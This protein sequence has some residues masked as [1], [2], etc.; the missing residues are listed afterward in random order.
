MASNRPPPASR[1]SVTVADAPAAIAPRLAE[2]TPAWSISAGP[3]LDVAEIELDVGGQRYGRGHAGGIRQSKIG[4]RDRVC[5]IRLV[6]WGSRA[7]RNR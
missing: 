7:R 5:P 4:H 1:S 3:W 6:A 2:T